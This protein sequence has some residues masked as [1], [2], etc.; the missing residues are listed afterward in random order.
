MDGECQFVYHQKIVNP[1]ESG[2]VSVIIHHLKL[3]A[4]FFEI[5]LTIW[6]FYRG[7]GRI[8]H[9]RSR[10]AFLRAQ[11]SLEENHPSI[12]LW[13]SRI[14]FFCLT[15]LFDQTGRKYIDLYIYILSKYMLKYIDTVVFKAC[16][17]H[18]KKH[19]QIVFSLTLM[20]FE[21][22]RAQLLFRKHL[23]PTS[24]SINRYGWFYP[25]FPK[26]QTS[27]NIG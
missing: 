21:I 9:Q 8:R 1:N 25:Q 2:V 17:K 7:A 19:I 10:Y 12:S 4:H 11:L 5:S 20:H 18:S 27:H 16:N 26:C 15:R 22:F 13:L 14:C 6:P 3:F 23:G 24:S